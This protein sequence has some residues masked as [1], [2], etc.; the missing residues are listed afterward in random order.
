M[1]KQIAADR[2]TKEV[3]KLID[4][5]VRAIVSNYIWLSYDEVVKAFEEHATLFDALEA[6]IEIHNKVLRSE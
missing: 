5:V 6:M 2:N 4:D 1:D 3:E